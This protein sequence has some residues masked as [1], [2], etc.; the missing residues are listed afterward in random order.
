MD[1]KEVRIAAPLSVAERGGGDV[2]AAK[3]GCGFDEAAAFDS[4]GLLVWVAGGD[5]GFLFVGIVRNPVGLRA[6]L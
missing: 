3:C 5:S 6:A 4:A 2:L 1:R